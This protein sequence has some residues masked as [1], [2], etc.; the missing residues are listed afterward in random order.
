MSS[1]RGMLASI[2]LTIGLVRL[3]YRFLAGRP[4]NGERKTDATFMRPATRSLDPSGTALRW[5]MMRGA[6]RLAYR[7]TAV[8]W[9]C[10]TVALLLMRLVSATGVHAPW[11]L[12]PMPVLML[13]VSLFGIP[14]VSWLMRRH[15][16]EHGLRLPY[17][18]HAETETGK[19]WEVR[20]AEISVGRRSW[21][22]EVVLPLGRALAPQLQLSPL[23]REIREWLTV[24]HS[25]REDGGAPVEVRLPHGYA[26]QEK[27]RSSVVSLAG[28]KLGLRE[29]SAS[30][31]LEGSAPR[32][33][34]SAPSLPPTH[35]LFGDVRS[36]LENSEE[37][38]PF[39]GMV[40]SDKA[41]HA[42]M[43]EASPHIGV[44]GGPGAGKSTLAKLVAMQALRWGWGVVVLDWK[45]TEAFSWM[46]GLPGV[47]YVSKIE[48]IHDY[49]VRI[50]QEIDRR[51]EEGMTGR[52]NVLVIRDEWN[53][54]AELLMAYWQDQRST[55]D[56]PE[57][58]KKMPLR[59][60]ALRGFATLDFAGREF[61]LFDFLIA[62]R[63]SSRVFNGNAD[64]RECFGIRCLSRYS[65]QTK[66]MLVGNLKPFPRKSNIPGRWT[67]VSGEDVAVVQV[68]LITNEE[69]RAFA[70]GGKENPITP[71]SSSYYP[72]L[73]DDGVTEVR[74]SNTQGDVLS[75]D[76]T[77]RNTS[78]LDSP[79]LD[80]NVVSSVEAAE[81]V[82]PTTRKLRDLAD[83]FAHLGITYNVLRN[84][85][86]DDE[87]GD[88]SFPAAYGGSQFSGYTYDVAKVKEWARARHASQRAVK[89]IK[90]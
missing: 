30:W 44:S 12:R 16:R 18:T 7:L 89:E 58:K 31:Q 33:I 65:H 32:L 19:A 36:W 78:D 26:G 5:E 45:C 34:I 87:K 17:L 8:Y 57:L 52:A 29:P 67:I 59:S 75:L 11:Y 73:S 86:R 68:P 90:A 85:A 9:I 46:K 64:I 6:A 72:Q 43:I 81:M 70:T 3:V 76:A 42:E 83:T 39:M 80:G 51:K 37:Y 63:F 2:R 35:V 56:D 60:P 88:P 71:F 38:R 13:N 74:G 4:M 15:V 21:E 48:G 40:G 69:A 61:G 27:A 22:R 66:Q 54:T 79:H 82:E 10:L 77:G 24:P 1:A 53:A 55:E 49:G 84:A 20:I 47:T 50:G 41:M 14:F 23:D 28:E 62:Q 25:F